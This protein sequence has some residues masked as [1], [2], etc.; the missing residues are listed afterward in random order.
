[1][2]N[3]SLEIGSANQNPIEKEAGLE[4]NLT[5]SRDIILSLLS[6]AAEDRVFLARLAEN[7]YEVLLEYNLNKEERLAL[8]EGD[9]NKIEALVG[10]LD[11][12]LKTWFHVRNN[13][14]RW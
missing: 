9:S 3:D 6:R 12:R 5:T 11:D 10:K 14:G 1:M 2:S 7:P 13:Q 4:N 8:F